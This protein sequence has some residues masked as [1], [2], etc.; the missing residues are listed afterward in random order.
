MFIDVVV[1]FQWREIESDAV[2][3]WI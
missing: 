3:C 1:G 2:E